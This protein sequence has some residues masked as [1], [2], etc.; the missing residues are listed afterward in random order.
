MTLTRRELVAGA[1][2]SLLAAQRQR[3][4]FV[5]ILS[6]DHHY[7]TLGTSGNPHVRTPN[8]DR[9]A[10]RGVYLGNGAI[11]TAQCAPS[12]GIL[13]SGLETFQSA[14]VSNGQTEF[15]KDIGPTAIE[16]LRRGGYDTVLIGKWHIRNQPRECGFTRA[17]LW[18][19][20][21]A[22]PYRDPQLS[23]GLDGKPEVVPGHITDLFSAAAIEVVQAAARPGSQPFFLWLA[24][25]APHTPWYAAFQYREAYQNKEVASLAPPAHP[26]SARPFDWATYYSVITHLDEAVGRV[27]AEIDRAGLWDSTYVFFIGDNGF[28]CGTKGENGKVVPWEESVRVPFIAA[29]GKLRRGVKSDSPVSS[30]DLPATWMELAGVRPAYRLSGRSL[31]G[32]LKTGKGG[33]DEGFVSW[34]DGRPE[35]LAVNRAVEPYRLVRSRTH[36]LIVWESGRQALYD[37][38]SDP[39]EEHD[40]AQRPE[41]AKTMAKL[42]GLLTARMKETKDPAITWV[43]SS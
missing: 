23:R 27:V 17:P 33:P 26:K 25:N 41:S 7:Q 37:Y 22:S 20:G 13:L 34:V 40:L 42:R 2:S 21:G 12:R 15:R 6:D 36:K 11:S 32:L 5:F 30:I 43:R 10:W 28:M 35:A 38:R 4:N 18:L 39:G 19:R 3:P 29:G 9:L 8:L 14:L 24:Y 16:Q 1:A 31:S